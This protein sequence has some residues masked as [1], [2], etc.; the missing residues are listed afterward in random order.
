MTTKRFRTG[1]WLTSALTAAALLP[2]QA[3][4]Q[5]A[6]DEGGLEEIIVTAQKR[7]Q[8]VQDVPIAVTAVNEASLQANRIYTVNDLSSIAP[9]LTVKPSAG[10]ISTPSF[11]MRG[12]VSFGVVAGSD[13]QVSVYVDGVYI[14]APRGS[15]FDLP[16]IQ[17]LEVLRGPQGTLFGRNATAG[18]VSITTRDPG[19]EFRAR[20]EGTVGNYDAY[21]IRTTVET[22]TFGPFSALFSYVRNYRRGEIENS[23][24]GLAWDRTNSASGFG[25]AVSPRWLGTIDSNS[26]FAAVKFEPSDRFKMV[27]KYDRN[28]D[29]GTP[30][31]TSIASYD[32]TAQIFAGS[33]PILGNVLT[34]LYTSNNV[35]FNPSAKRPDIVDNGWVIPRQQRVQGHSL[36]ATWKATDS[37]TVKNIAAYRKATVFAPSA[38]DGVST[39]TF[40]QATVQPF[41]LLSAFSQVPNFAATFFAAAAGDPVAIATRDASVAAVAAGLQPLVGQRIAIIASQASSIAKQY[42]DEIIVNYSS[43]KLQATLG[44]IW[45]KSD[46][47]S[48]GPIGQQNTLQFPSFISPTGVIPLRNEGRSFNKATSIAAYL[49]LEYKVTPEVEI[50]A[51]ARITH[52]KKTSQFRWDTPASATLPLGVPTNIIPGSFSKTKPNF[53]IGLNYTPNSDTLVYAKYSTSFVSGGQVAGISY[54]PETAKS[55]E[56]GLKADFLDRK[57]RTNLALFH[58]TYDHFQ[59]PQGTSSGP[60][61]QL[62]ISLLTPRFTPANATPAELATATATATALA[63]ALSTFRY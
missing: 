33:G 19:G 9:G 13:K 58:V 30:E 5:D 34:A 24:A 21:R 50:V 23:Q 1:L 46:D 63:S 39:L 47:Q 12:Q 43:E 44:G 49:Q 41:A 4:A 62:A 10:G 53:M 40:T 7:E 14:S 59:S 37:I 45:F 32:R 29:N 48:G 54:E 28:D 27:Y 8:S 56:V 36:T 38:I 3:F 16:D 25:K 61:G 35:H 18:A 20:I 55:W 42:S 51:G 60:S 17:R 22:P 6:A 57:L 11:T 31:G 52:D 15:I 2:S 26:Y